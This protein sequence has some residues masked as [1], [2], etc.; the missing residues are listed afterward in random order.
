MLPLAGW[1]SEKMVLRYAHL[2]SGHHLFWRDARPAIPRSFWLGG[3]AS[4]NG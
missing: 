2:A 4:A 1:E 3:P